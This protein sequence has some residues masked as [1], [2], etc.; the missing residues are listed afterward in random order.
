MDSSTERQSRNQKGRQLSSLEEE[1]EEE[2]ENEDEN[3]GGPRELSWIVR[4]GTHFFVCFVVSYVCVASIP[5]E[6]ESL[7]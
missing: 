2:E 4:K 3:L 1:E 7:D 6:L 5:G